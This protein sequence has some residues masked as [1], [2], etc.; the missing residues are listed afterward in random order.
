MSVLKETGMAWPVS[1]VQPLKS[2]IQ[3]LS[4]VDAQPGKTGTESVVL[5]AHQ[6]KTGMLSQGPV[7]A[8]LHQTGTGIPALTATVEEYGVM[9][10]DFVSVH[11]VAGTDSHVSLV[12]L[13][14]PGTQLDFHVHAQ[15]IPTGTAL[16]VRLAQ[17][18]EYGAIKSMIVFV[19]LEIGMDLSV[20]SVHRIPTG[21]ERP[22]FLVMETGS[23]TH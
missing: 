19:I 5:L 3:L 9:P 6:D 13:G 8:Q 18:T 17:E 2:G 10:Q 7:G 23:G 1:N 12:A 14:K 16:I 20:L 11:Q 4:L 22:V 15:P 21:T